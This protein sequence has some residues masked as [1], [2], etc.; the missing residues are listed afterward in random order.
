MK[1][2]NSLLTEILVTPE[3]V[4]KKL[5]K[6]K[7]DKSAGPDGIHPK[8]LYEV[9]S[10]IN[11]VYSSINPYQMDFYRMT[12]KLL[13]SQRYIFFISCRHKWC[14]SRQ[15]PW[16]VLFLTFINDLPDTVSL[17]QLNKKNCR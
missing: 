12:A 2:M 1:D 13:F 9:R 10:A 4:L 3:E 6:L 16:P 8:V 7:T 11:Q 14:T 17:I 5:S 15:C